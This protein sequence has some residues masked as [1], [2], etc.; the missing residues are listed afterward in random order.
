MHPPV[1]VCHFISAKP[2]RHRGVWIPLLHWT[3]WAMVLQRLDAPSP[4]DGDVPSVQLAPMDIGSVA[5]MLLK[6]GRSCPIKHVCMHAESC[7]CRKP[8]G[9]L[10]TW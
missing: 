7:S 4:S 2:A 8:T 9:Q 10:V 3:S 1:G 5:V 6:G